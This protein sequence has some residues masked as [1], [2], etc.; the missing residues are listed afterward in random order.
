MATI[1]SANSTFSIAVTGLFPAPQLLQGYAADDAFSAEAIDMA[2]VVMGVD[3]QMSYGWVF[4]PTPMTV[5]LM[6]TS[7]SLAIFEAWT[8]LQKAQ[9]EVYRCDGA[10]RLPAI[11]RSYVLK[12]GVLKNASQMPA[13]KKT[14]QPMTFQ[15][16]WE[17]IISEPI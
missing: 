12:N 13:V 14:L 15:I 16:V 5:T 4:N 1:T 2:E 9:Q 8:N 10:I 6:P 17:R 11:G 3:G 7:P